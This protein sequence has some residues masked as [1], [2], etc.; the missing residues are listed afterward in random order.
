MAEYYCADVRPNSGSAQ[1]NALLQPAR[2]E[3]LSVI[4]QP[5]ND[6][7]RHLMTGISRAREKR[8]EYGERGS[9]CARQQLD[10]ARTL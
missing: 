5:D 7:R 10:Y 1:R 9:L 3:R 8:G 6:S 4:V 2:A